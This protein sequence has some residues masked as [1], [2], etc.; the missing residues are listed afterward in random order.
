M[1]AKEARAA[2]LTAL[3]EA[4]LEE[5]IPARGWGAARSSPCLALSSDRSLFFQ[6]E[7]SW[8][9]TVGLTH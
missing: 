5:L 6:R 4:A 2:L 3:A 7:N 1:C 8:S 9:L